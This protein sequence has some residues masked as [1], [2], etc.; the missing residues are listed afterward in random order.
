MDK[1][2][3]V[4][5]LKEPDL[6]EGKMKAVRVK[7]KP[8]LLAKVGGEVFGISN[9]CPHAGCSFQGGI[10]SGYIVVCPCHGWKFDVRNGQYQETNL[11][12]VPCYLCKVENGKIYVKIPK[13]Q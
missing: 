5:C 10:L 12:T 11:V 4:A 8:I 7:G 2:G 13:D 3:Y 6:A 1:D 9:V